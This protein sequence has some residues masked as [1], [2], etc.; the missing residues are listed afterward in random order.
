MRMGPESP[1]WR[2]LLSVLIFPKIAGAQVRSAAPQ[3]GSED[4]SPCNIVWRSLDLN[5]ISASLG[6]SISEYL[7]D[8]WFL[9]GMVLLRKNSGHNRDD[10]DHVRSNLHAFVPPESPNLNVAQLHM[11][12]FDWR[13][14]CQLWWPRKNVPMYG[15]TVRRL[16][17]FWEHEPAQSPL[18]CPVNISGLMNQCPEFSITLAAR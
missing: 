5:T 14:S 13:Q 3:V 10:N 15:P 9:Q 16:N 1:I 8:S 17:D 12:N 18:R 11:T 4:H 2:L 7:N 6:T